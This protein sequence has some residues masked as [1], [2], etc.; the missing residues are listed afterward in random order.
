M[1]NRERHRAQ[2]LLAVG[3][4]ALALVLL[5]A[6]GLM[7][8]SFQSLRSQDPGFRSPEE[9]LA[10]RLY[11]PGS[12]A[13]R[14][15]DVALTYEM[16]ARR[17]QQVPGV[18]SVGLATAIPMDGSGNVN[19]FLV[20]GQDFDA[21]GARV[22][23]RHKWIGPDYLETMQIPLLLG[24]TVTWEEIHARSPVALLSETLAREVFGSPEEALGQYVAARPDPPQWKE[25]IGI[26]ADVREDGMDR[27]PPALVYWPHV[28]LGFWEGNAPDQVQV[29]RSAGFAIRSTRVN[30]PGFLEDVQSAIWEVSPNLPLMGVRPLTELMADSM[31]RTSFTLMLLGVAGASALLLGLVGVY[32]VITYAVSQRTRELGMRMALGAQPGQVQRMVL[33]QGLVLAGAGV[34]V[35]LG[36]A[37]GLTRLMS[38]LLYDVSP[39]DPVTFGTVA[40]GLLGVALLASYLPARRA[41]KVDP[42][43]ALRLD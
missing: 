37:F 33:G 27:P 36:M 28:T 32:G 15:A 20:Q 25:V 40:A 41:A 8:R 42:M 10:L 16:I 7:L 17:L 4:M 21:E 5:V 35:G 30:T 2:N 19:P 13:P 26:V 14:G 11:I 9:V 39:A 43:A 24:R 12:E 34:G 29:W 18:A 22:S 6:A 23:R 1:R 3:Q 38:A 31:A